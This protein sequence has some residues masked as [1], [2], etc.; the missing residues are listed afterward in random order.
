MAKQA[1]RATITIL[2]IHVER[3]GGRERSGEGE[4]G[5]GEGRVMTP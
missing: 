5:F 3:E 2:N 4:V 1:L